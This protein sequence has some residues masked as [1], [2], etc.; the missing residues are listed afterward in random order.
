MGG[1]RLWLTSEQ[2]IARKAPRSSIMEAGVLLSC[3]CRDEFAATGIG[4]CGTDTSAPRRSRSVAELRPVAIHVHRSREQPRE[5]IGTVQLMGVPPATG[6]SAA[7]G[8]QLEPEPHTR[9][10]EPTVTMEVAREDN[11]RR[12]FDDNPTIKP[13]RYGEHAAAAYAATLRH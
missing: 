10:N 2:A 9:R 13:P 12:I 8:S 5:R 11:W 6:A 4:I 7:S 1:L 3:K